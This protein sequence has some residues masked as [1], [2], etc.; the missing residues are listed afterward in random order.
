MNRSARRTRALAVLWLILTFPAVADAL[1]IYADTS[2]PGPR[3]AFE[4]LVQDF[5]TAHPEIGVELRIYDHEGFKSAIRQFLLFDAPDVVTWY[6]GNRMRFFVDRGL[7]A[8][9]SD[10]WQA[11]GLEQSM[12]PSRPALTVDNQQYGVPYTYY[13]WGV[14][15]RKDLFEQHGLA[16]PETWDA[17]LAACAALKNRGITPITIGTSQLWPAAGWFDYLD[18][19]LNGLAFHRELTAGAIPYTDDR[20]RRVFDH[21]RRLIEPGYFIADHAER[22]W[23]VALDPLFE[24][25][26]AMVLLGNF[27]VPFFREAGIIEQIGFFPF[28]QIDPAVPRYEDAP[29]DTVHIPANAAHKADARKFLTFIA[30]ADIQAKMNRMLGQLPAN[31]DAPVPD[32][33]F[34]DAGRT[35]LGEAAGLA[36][37]YDRDTQPEMARIGM[38]GFRKFMQQPE[39]LD[40]ILERLEIERRRIYEIRR[41]PKQ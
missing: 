36:Q 14:Y 41:P 21:W 5:R 31:R 1:V 24:G 12:A 3:A 13:Q 9:V 27:V 38:L 35:L 25:R 32:V 23:Q 20:V 19:R 7:F 17:F 28:P 4:Q 16:V 18:L 6:A 40:T 30:R 29:I 10:L 37:F 26:A 15:Y 39:R 2:D 11:D 34:L 8:D 33:P 22:T